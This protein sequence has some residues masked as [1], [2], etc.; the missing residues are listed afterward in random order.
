[1]NFAQARAKKANANE[2]LRMRNLH[3]VLGKGF[4]EALR[5]RG[6]QIMYVDDQ[7]W[8]Y[9]E[10]L[11]QSYVPEREKEWL[12]REI[13]AGFRVLNMPSR[14]NVVNET[15]GWIQR[16][17]DIHVEHVDWD[18]HGKI[19]TRTG[20]V[21][22]RTL[23]VT[24]LRPEHHCTYRIG[25]EYDPDATCPQWERMLGDCFTDQETINVLQE[26]VGAALVDNKP[27]EL[28]RALVL[29][30]PS[31]SGKSNLLNAMAGFLSDHAITTSFDTLENA[32]GLMPF[33]RRAP[34]L[35]HEAFDQ[36]KWHPSATVKALLSGDP[37]GVN[38]KNGPMVT[39]RFRSPV[40]WG[41]NSR[42][43]FKE[44]SKA[45]IN[46]MVIVVCSVVFSDDDRVGAAM[47]AHRLGYSGPAEMVLDVERSGMLNWAL[48]GLRRALDRGHFVLTANMK[49]ILNEVQKQANLVETFMEE[50]V[51][52]APTKKIKH[53]DFC[54]AYGM[55]WVESRGNH[56]V[57][58]NDSIGTALRDL[59]DSRL[60]FKRTGSNRYII[61]IKLNELGMTYWLA[62]HNLALLGKGVERHS[63]ISSD[64]KEVERDV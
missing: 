53:A 62:A 22:P 39:H 29:V 46:R 4:L 15:R 11:W 56:A 43:K 1:M 16:N 25:C 37:V 64:P 60:D 47:E 3:G 23:T 20:L 57:P 52:Y 34:W 40:F 12:N 6:E 54:A 35:L 38:I 44:P 59:A 36:S 14:N 27:R 33:L 48:E 61:G 9:R 49:A 24:P 2:P 31:N 8:R 13:E 42:P 26:I 18:A 58:S 55:R 41:A 32:H 21:D 7:L 5:E 10:G 45:M 28:M 30:G 17:P 51:E 50:C 19:P 63:N